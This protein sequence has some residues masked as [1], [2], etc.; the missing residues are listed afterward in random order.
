MWANRGSRGRVREAGAAI[1]VTASRVPPVVHV[2]RR[3]FAAPASQLGALIPRLG[4]PTDAIWPRHRWPP[5]ELASHEVGAEGRHG[6][7]RYVVEE[8]VAGERIRFR[9]TAPSGF[10][11]HHEFTVIPDG[12]AAILEHRIEM[13]TVGF[14]AFL[15][16][17]VLGPL[18]D[19]LAADAGATT[20]RSIGED[21][22]D[23]AWS[24]WVRFLRF[25]ASVAG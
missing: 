2:S 5:M 25:I 22:G 4:T 24:P 19:A 21:A 8:R 1:R 16:P 18:H 20:A 17:C 6:P 13:R 14:A 10:V 23:P 11:G 15:W 7:V 3:R 12:E 9:F